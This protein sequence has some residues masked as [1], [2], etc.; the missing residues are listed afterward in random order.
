MDYVTDERKGLSH[1]HINRLHVSNNIHNH[2]SKY[3]PCQQTTS[4]CERHF[5]ISEVNGQFIKEQCDGFC[6]CTLDKKGTTAISNVLHL[7]L[8]KKKKNLESL[9]NPKRYLLCV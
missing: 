3:N 8:R 2:N 5:R 4:V 6:P 9:S 7:S 1:I